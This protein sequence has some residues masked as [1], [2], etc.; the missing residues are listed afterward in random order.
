MKGSHFKRCQAAIAGGAISLL[1]PNTTAMIEDTT[2]D[3]CEVAA[4]VT[5]SEDNSCFEDSGEL[6]CSGEHLNGN[7]F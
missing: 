4:T 2:F 6:S 7:G 1:G 5:Y 3:E